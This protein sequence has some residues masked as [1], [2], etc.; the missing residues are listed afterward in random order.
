[1]VYIEPPDTFEQMIAPYPAMI[2]TTASKLQHL[3]L[4]N[5]PQLTEQVSGGNKVANALYSFT[6]PNQVVCGIQAGNNA[7]KL[8]IHHFEQAR[9]MGF[10]IEGSGKHARHIKFH[11]PDDIQ[12]DTLVPLLHKIWIATGYH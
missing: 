12:A 11:H 10:N 9:G 7:C 1:M 3:I 2:Q 4:N 8:F 6:A 5:L